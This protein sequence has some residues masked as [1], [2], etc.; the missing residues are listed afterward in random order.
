[1]VVIKRSDFEEFFN[2]N[3]VSEKMDCFKIYFV[4]SCRGNRDGVMLPKVI[5]N[6]E[7]KAIN[8]RS[9]GNGIQNA[10]VDWIHPEDN[11]SIMYSNANNYQSFE[12]PYD[13]ITKDIAWDQIEDEEEKMDQDYVYSG[14]F[15]NAVCA[16]LED[17][18][19]RRFNGNLSKIQDKIRQK[20]RI[21]K[22]NKVQR[23]YGLA[24]NESVN[25]ENSIKEK[26]VFKSNNS[27]QWDKKKIQLLN[28]AA[29]INEGN[30]KYA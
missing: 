25:F 9:K 8:I 27:K 13:P 29:E 28:D 26:L 2:G 24:I 22:N 5:N 14:I 30:V 23:K 10:C 7:R 19:R 21:Q 18:V 11:I 12:A 15:T 6:A 20:S 3:N 4:D 16:T 17:N 1:M